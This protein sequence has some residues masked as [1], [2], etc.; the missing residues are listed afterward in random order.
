MHMNGISNGDD[1]R[2]ARSLIDAVPLSGRRLDSEF[3]FRGDPPP[4][5]SDDAASSFVSVGEAAILVVASF[6]PTVLRK[7][8]G[9]LGGG[10]NCRQ[11]PMG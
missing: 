2:P 5:A 4:S 6:A 3:H 8:A 9:S 1:I 10:A 11:P 7:V